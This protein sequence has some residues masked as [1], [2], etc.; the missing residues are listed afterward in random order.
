[1]LT[2]QVDSLCKIIFTTYSFFSFGID[3]TCHFFV[4]SLTY[5]KSHI[6]DRSMN[7]LCY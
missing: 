7:A 3:I 4:R 1:M 6:R 2:T 5:D